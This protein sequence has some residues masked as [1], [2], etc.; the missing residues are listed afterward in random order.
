V[1]E[2]RV[3]GTASTKRSREVKRN[4]EKAVLARFGSFTAGEEDEGGE[5]G[6]ATAAAPD[7]EVGGEVFAENCSVGHGATGHGGNG[8]PDLTTMPK[9]FEGIVGG[10]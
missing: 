4:H 8:G 10:K 7:A 5:E 6:K 1:L 3:I 9:D 2:F